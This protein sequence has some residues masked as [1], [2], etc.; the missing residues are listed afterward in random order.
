MTETKQATSVGL[1]FPEQESQRAAAAVAAGQPLPKPVEEPAPLPTD[2][3][4]IAMRVDAPMIFHSED[5]PPTAATVP[6]KNLAAVE[7]PILLS[8]Q[9]PIRQSSQGKH[10]YQKIGGAFSRVFKGKSSS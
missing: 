1:G 5:L 6:R 2:P 9:P 7:F 8:V 3:G 10:W 4:E